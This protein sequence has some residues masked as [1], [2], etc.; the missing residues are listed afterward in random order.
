MP[1]EIMPVGRLIRWSSNG[2]L[3]RNHG[4]DPWSRH[5]G[6][7]VDKFSRWKGFS[8]N[9]YVFPLVSIIPLILILTLIQISLF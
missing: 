8:L 2:L 5:V 4:L 7:V 3:P 9:A 6:F 1:S